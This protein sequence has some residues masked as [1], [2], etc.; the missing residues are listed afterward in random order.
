MEEVKPMNMNTEEVVDKALGF[1]KNKGGF[2]WIHL[3]EV[4]S[5]E[6]N[7]LWKISID[8]G[9]LEK[10]TKTVTID[11]KDGKVVGYE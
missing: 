2:P 5:N 1:V 8:V 9:V 10:K 4:T 7:G 3:E 11:D 6:S